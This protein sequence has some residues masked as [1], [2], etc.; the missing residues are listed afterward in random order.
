MVYFLGLKY[1]LTINCQRACYSKVGTLAVCCNQHLVH[2]HVI[3][4]T[5]HA[6]VC[7]MVSMVGWRQSVLHA[8]AD[9]EWQ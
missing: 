2:Y 8:T 7:E 6:C 3:M 5:M 9:T 1:P 4:H